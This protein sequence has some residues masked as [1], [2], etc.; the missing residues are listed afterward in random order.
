MT[1]FQFTP[2]DILAS[3]SAQAIIYRLAEP[4]EGA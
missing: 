3:P 2:D 4:Q 1:V